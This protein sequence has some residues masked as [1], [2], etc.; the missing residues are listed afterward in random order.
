MV[1]LSLVHTKKKRMEVVL[2][3]MKKERLSE[4]FKL[5]LKPE[6]WYILQWNTWMSL[7]TYVVWEVYGANLILTM[8]HG[9]LHP[10]S[11]G[12]CKTKRKNLKSCFKYKNKQNSNANLEQTQCTFVYVQP[13]KACLYLLLH[14]HTPTEPLSGCDW[15]TKNVIQPT[16]DPSGNSFEAYWGLLMCFNVRGYFFL[17]ILLWAKEKWCCTSQAILAFFLMFQKKKE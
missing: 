15:V 12:R 6:L 5:C 4:K 11:E 3:R 10:H 7:W 8:C 1:L 9:G 2:W 16:D 13:R 17:L 14:L